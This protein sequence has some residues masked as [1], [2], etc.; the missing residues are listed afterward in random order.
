MREDTQNN[1]GNTDVKVNSLTAGNVHHSQNM[2][3]VIPVGASYY[4]DP[5]KYLKI[6]VLI[7]SGANTSIIRRDVVEQLNLPGK[8]IQVVLHGVNISE[9]YE[10]IEVDLRIRGIDSSE[11]YLMKNVVC[12]DKLPRHGNSID[13]E[14]NSEQCPHLEGIKIH[15]VV[16]DRIDVIIGNDNEHLLDFKDIRRGNNC[17][18]AKLS[19]FGWVLVGS[20]YSTNKI[21]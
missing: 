7:D 20:G 10:T 13:C 8:P 18:T 11:M 21:K 6:N 1:S 2:L 14:F 4:D 16:S 12:V 9:S 3:P 15:W 5:K 19:V 17:P